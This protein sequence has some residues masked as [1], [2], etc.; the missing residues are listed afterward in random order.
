MRNSKCGMR[1][2][3]LRKW[4]AENREMHS[5]EGIKHS[6]QVTG[7][8]LMLRFWD[9]FGSQLGLMIKGLIIGHQN[10][11]NST[12]RIPHSEFERPV[13]RPPQRGT[14]RPRTYGRFLLHR[15]AWSAPVWRVGIRVGEK[16]F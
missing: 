2:S 15:P 4:K 3:N 8:Q 16:T 7:C 9:D 11:L 6:A 12:F 5:D 1:N 13:P 14:S 10:F